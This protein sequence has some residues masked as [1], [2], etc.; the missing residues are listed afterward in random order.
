[1]E[2]IV[3]FLVAHVREEAFLM[4]DRVIN[5]FDDHSLCDHAEHV[6]GNEGLTPDRLVRPQVSLTDTGKISRVVEDST[7]ENLND[8]V[9]NGHSNLEPEVPFHHLFEHQ[10]DF[11]HVN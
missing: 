11:L 4:R 9:V 7:P 5:A 6:K 3:A 1:M 10:L 2:I 8:D